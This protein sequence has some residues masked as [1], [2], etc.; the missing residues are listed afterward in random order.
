M[1]LK[2]YGIEP[3]AAPTDNFADAGS[4]YYTGYLAAAKAEGISSG[5]GDNN[6]APEKSITR[7]E[8]FTLLYN[9]LKAIDQLPPG[10][11]GKTLTD[12]SDANRV[13]DWATEAMT[14]LVK[15]D[16]VSG[17]DGK[18]DPTGGSTRAQMAQ[19]LYNLL[20]K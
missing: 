2:A 8:M 11:S 9:A 16:T 20:R 17:S 3:I 7:Q 12:F 19:V 10:D 14:A 18:L 15:S 6:F 1:L 4:T 5:V 13:A